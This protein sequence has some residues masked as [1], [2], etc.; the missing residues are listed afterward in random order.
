MFL[1]K[2]EP[3]TRAR[4]YPRDVRTV[5]PVATA[6]LGARA[7]FARSWPRG[8]VVA[9]ETPNVV[10]PDAALNVIGRCDLGSKRVR[11]SRLVRRVWLLRARRR[12]R[13]DERGRFRHA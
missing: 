6:V 8:C 1:A 3:N 10:I 12:R 11:A 9:S 7:Y 2:A 5:V 4:G 13:T